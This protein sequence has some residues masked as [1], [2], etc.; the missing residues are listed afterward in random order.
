[1]AIDEVTLPEQFEKQHLCLSS[2][3]ASVLQAHQLG[4]PAAEE[5]GAALQA[6]PGM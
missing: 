4:R 6:A 2:V 1:M 3:E 5:G